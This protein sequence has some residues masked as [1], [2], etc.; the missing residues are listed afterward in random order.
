MSVVYQN[1][2]AGLTSV[3][4]IEK[5]R[6]QNKVKFSFTNERGEAPT[7]VNKHYEKQQTETDGTKC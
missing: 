7:W 3:H 4:V 5:T 6:R 2:T 1:P